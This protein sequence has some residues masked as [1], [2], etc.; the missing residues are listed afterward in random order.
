MMTQWIKILLITTM[1]LLAFNFIWGQEGKH[2]VSFYIG[3][4]P[5]K[6]DLRY[7]FLYNQYPIL[8]IEGVQ[9]KIKNTTNDDEYFLGIS[10]Q[11]QPIKRINFGFGL[12]YAQLKQDFFLPANG[13]YFEQKIYPFF[14]RDYS[15]YHMVQI[16]PEIKVDILKYKSMVLGINT[17]LISNISFR[18]EINYRDGTANDIAVNKTEFFA[19]ELYPAIFASI[20]RVRFDISYRALHWKYR[21]DAIANNGLNVDTYNPSKWRFQLSYE[22]WRSKKK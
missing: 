18:K 12:G 16:S 3:Y 15:R 8:I 6:P 10:Y 7:D 5:G 4:A 1:V 21:D 19:T 9:S 11:Y 22:F 14:W 17:R 20:A 13:K 2:N